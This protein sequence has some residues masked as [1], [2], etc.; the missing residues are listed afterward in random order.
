MQLVSWSMPPGARFTIY[1]TSLGT[2]TYRLNTNGAAGCTITTWPGNIPRGVH[3]HGNW[4]FSALGNYSLTFK[5][6]AQ[7][8]A[9]VTS[10]NVTYTFQVG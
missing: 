6:T 2:P 1:T 5:A 8:G 3:G 7:G 10:G 4:A 9:G